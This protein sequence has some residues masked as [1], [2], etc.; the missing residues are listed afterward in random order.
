MVTSSIRRLLCARRTTSIQ[1]QVRY[2][3]GLR[4]GFP[5]FVESLEDRCVP[6][7]L[8]VNPAVPADYPNIKAAINAAAGGDTIQVVPGT[9]GGSNNL[10]F[11][12]NKPITIESTDGAATTFIE[13]S[14]NN[15][16]FV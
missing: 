7:I 1:R 15:F 13:C 10:G 5:P 11:S 12:L 4:P 14:T 3:L 9:Y 6:T 16:A 2:R 8:I